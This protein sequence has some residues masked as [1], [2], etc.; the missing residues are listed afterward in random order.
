MTRTRACWCFAVGL[1]AVSG[2]G[3]RDALTGSDGAAAKV[4]DQRF[5]VD[6]LASIM[7]TGNNVPISK[8]FA[9]RLAHR[10]VEYALFAERIA[11][12]T[13]C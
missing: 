4:G 5:A 13:P 12:Q 7:V 3:L 8:E 9:E 1:V 10:W 11:L 2:C 6:R